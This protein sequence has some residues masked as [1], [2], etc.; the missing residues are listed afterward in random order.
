MF[1][2]A[3]TPFN[4][5]NTNNVYYKHKFI[6]IGIYETITEQLTGI[7]F[8]NFQNRLDNCAFELISS[9][10]NQTK[11]LSIYSMIFPQLETTQ[12][13]L[14]PM[15][16]KLLNKYTFVLN[17]KMRFKPCF[18]L[19]L[20]SYLSISLTNIIIWTFEMIMKCCNTIFMMNLFHKFRFLVCFVY[21]TLQDENVKIM[22]RTFL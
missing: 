19:F 10:T 15:K 20:W 4:F 16:R 5:K 21:M 3:T 14:K 6:V 13:F 11:L 9:Q 8:R 7:E 17:F 18:W 12:F 22:I 1:G 2:V